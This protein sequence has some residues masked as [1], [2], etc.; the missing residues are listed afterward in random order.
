[1]GTHDRRWLPLRPAVIVGPMI[2][3][4]F[5]TLCADSVAETAAFYRE[6]FGFEEVFVAD[7]YVQLQAPGE[8]LTQLAVVARDHDSVPPDERRAPAGVLIGVEVDD[9]DEV[10]ARLVAAGHPVIRSLRDEDWGQ[11]HF[12]SLDPSG[13]MVDVI[14]PIAPTTDEYVAAYAAGTT[15]A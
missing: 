2:T 15:G 7:W 1:V 8:P 9:V 4:T 14:T 3:S 12:I 11:R 10:H 5:P 6:L 13:A